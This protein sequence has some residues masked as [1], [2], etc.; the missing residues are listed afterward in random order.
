MVASLDASPWARVIRASDFIDT[1][2]GL[3]YI[4][5]WRLEY[6]A[7]KY[8]GLVAVLPETM[9][10]SDTPLGA[11]VRHAGSVFTRRRHGR[12]RGRR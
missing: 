11:P 10:R 3:I 4:T 8:A 5:E 12:G 7:S 9:S 1:G 6:L 2:V